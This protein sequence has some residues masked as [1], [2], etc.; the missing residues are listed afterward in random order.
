MARMIGLERG[1][2]TALCAALLLGC[3]VA[4]G[5]MG[6]VARAGEHQLSPSQVAGWFVVGEAIPLRRDVAERAAHRWIDFALFADRVATGD[7]LLDTATVLDAMWPEVYERLV[8]QYHEQLIAER[9]PTDSAAI[10]S[11][12]AEGEYR[13]ISHILVRTQPT[14][15][16]ADKEAARERAVA[17]RTRLL[18]GESWEAVNEENE[19]PGAKSRGGSLGVIARGATVPEFEAVAFALESGGLSE[20]TESQFGF[21][22][23]RRPAL[24]D[25]RAEYGDALSRVLVERVDLEVLE[26]VEEKWRLRVRSSAP[27]AMR[28]AA[29]APL[30]GLGSDDVLVTYRGGEFVVADFV[31]WLAAL[32]PQMQRRME[33]AG[34]DQLTEL[35]QG[36]TR[37]ELLVR[38]AKE[39]GARLSDEDFAAYKEQLRG[40]IDNVRSTLQLDSALAT[41]A[42][43]AERQQRVEQAVD[44][45]I[46]GLM[47]GQASGVVVPVFLAGVLRSEARWTVSDRGLDQALERAQLLRMESGVPTDSGQA[48]RVPEGDSASGAG[49]ER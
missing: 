38:D 31:R 29:A 42:T 4:G 40:E 45:Y 11:V 27:A 10:D 37:N 26:E 43:A 46:L 48:P 44:G 14:M 23:I 39:A 49:G 15:S 24:E 3:E 30:R 1:A 13:L 8:G 12:Y 36:L 18:N 28:E 21:H 2:V 22:I 34:D 19:D 35:A 20:V 6:I 47:S 32:P 25:V 17:L 33:M 9:V 16:P 41:A 5:D 7:S